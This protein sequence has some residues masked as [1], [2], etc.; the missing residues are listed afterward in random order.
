M[1]KFSKQKKG[2]LRIWSSGMTRGIKVVNAYKT[3]KIERSTDL[4]PE[5]SFI[6]L[7]KKKLTEFLYP[8]EARILLPLNFI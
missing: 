6:M 2:N 3:G 5:L 1:K 8:A 4:Y 7:A